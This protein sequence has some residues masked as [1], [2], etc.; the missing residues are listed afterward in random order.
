M[1][2]TKE[3]MQQ[4]DIQTAIEFYTGNHFKH[5]KISCPFHT[6]KTP[7][8]SIKNG[9][10]R[11]WSC[12]ASGSAIDFVR[13][14]FGLSFVEAVKKLSTD[15]NVQVDGL[16]SKSQRPDLWDEVRL[17]VA[18]ERAAEVTAEIMRLVDE[19]N[20]LAD[21]HRKLYRHGDFAGAER[22]ANRIEDLSEEIDF[23]MKCR[24]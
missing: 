18:A 3:V 17:Q 24:G 19:T 1:I 7:S 9:R 11:C 4:V 5:G 16:D 14:M 15:F 8:L 10:F 21:E 2:D 23:L 6:D 22:F 12:G 20:R 13:Q